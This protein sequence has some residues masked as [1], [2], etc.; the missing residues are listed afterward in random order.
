MTMVATQT[1]VPM[2]IREMSLNSVGADTIKGTEER[3]YHKEIAER[4]KRLETVDRMRS[5]VP[6][7]FSEGSGV[8]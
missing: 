4:E 5:S 8:L 7:L 1:P 2:T 6:L 3:Y